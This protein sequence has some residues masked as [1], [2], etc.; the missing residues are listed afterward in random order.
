MEKYICQICD[1]WR[2]PKIHG[3]N[4][5]PSD[6]CECICNRCLEYMGEPNKEEGEE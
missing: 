5:D 3:C 1:E 6:E 4:E 2:S